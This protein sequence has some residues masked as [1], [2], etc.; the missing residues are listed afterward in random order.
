MGGPSEWG[1]YTSIF[2]KKGDKFKFIYNS[3]V[4][5]TFKFIYADGQPS[6]IKY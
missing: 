5:Y 3:A 1:A 2:V 6:I 4:Y